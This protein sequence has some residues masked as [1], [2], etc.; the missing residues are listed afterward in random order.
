MLKKQNDCPKLSFIHEIDLKAEPIFQL[1]RICSIEKRF[2]WLRFLDLFGSFILSRLFFQLVAMFT[3]Y[4]ND[5]STI[6][7]ITKSIIYMVTDS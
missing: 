1:A 2:K 4:L 3:F 5:G 7:W 6:Y